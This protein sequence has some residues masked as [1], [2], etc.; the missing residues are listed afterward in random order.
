MPPRAA[1]NQAGQTGRASAKTTSRATARG[2]KKAPPK[3]VVVEE[4]VE[5]IAPPMRVFCVIAHPEPNRRSF[6][7][8][9]YRKCI[10]TLKLNSHEVI[11]SDLYDSDFTQLP[12][13]SDFD[14]PD[15]ELSYA[16]H[17]R[18]GQYNE[19]ILRYQSRIEWCTHLILFTPLHWLSP[20]AALMGWWEKV[21]GEGWAFA[22]NQQFEKGYMAGK[23]AMVV[24]TCGQDQM[25]YG[26]DAINISV[27]EL[28]YPLTYR[29]FA[30]CGFTPLRTQTFFGLSTADPQ[31]RVDMLNAW[32][33]HVMNLESRE[34]I[35]FLSAEQ[36]QQQGGH[37]MESNKQTNRKILAGL[38]DKVLIVPKDPYAINFD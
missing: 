24:V 3:E 13:L 25:Y 10:E 17:Q 36:L 11:T 32:A 7:H 1:P 30:M 34:V 5:Q 15:K 22:P 38:G 4:V 37:M 21:F 6:C 28:M 23:K 26:K 31:A 16:E 33:E 14:D 35:E 2:K 20:C 29:C 18:R 27:E 8:A 19:E 12:S 9:I